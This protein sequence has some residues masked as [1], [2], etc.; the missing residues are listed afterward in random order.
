MQSTKDPKRLGVDSVV[1]VEEL[2]DGHEVLE[3]LAHLPP[4]YMQVTRVEPALAPRPRQ[5]SI[6]AA[7]LGDLVLMVGKGEV[8]AARVQI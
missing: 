2:T 6:A 7:P 8:D 3:R 4:F 5:V 1:A